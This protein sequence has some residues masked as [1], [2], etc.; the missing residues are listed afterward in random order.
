MVEWSADARDKNLAPAALW[1]AV[2]GSMGPGVLGGAVHRF[3]EASDDPTSSQR[4]VRA[5]VLRCGGSS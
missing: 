3:V 5:P 4:P 2:R 1:I